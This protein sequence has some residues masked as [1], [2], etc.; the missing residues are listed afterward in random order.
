LAL[1]I[2]KIKDDLKAP[3]IELARNQRV[4]FNPEEITNYIEECMAIVEKHLSIDEFQ[5]HPL[6]VQFAKLISNEAV[7]ENF[8]LKLQFLDSHK[9]L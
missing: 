6:M 3:I 7:S 4:R 1:S 5:Q 2:D 9:C 8:K